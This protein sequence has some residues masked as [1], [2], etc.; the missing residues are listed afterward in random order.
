MNNQIF[1]EENNQ[2]KIDFS[3]ALWASDD[4]HNVYNRLGIC[5][6]D[7]VAETEEF[8]I[9][10]EYKNANI[11]N[12]INPE[13]FETKIRTDGHYKNIAQKFYDSLLYLLLNDKP[14]K[15]LR[16]VYILERNIDDSVLRRSVRNKIKSK[17]P[18][19]IQENYQTKVI[20][21]FDVLSI[22]EWNEAYS[23]YPIVQVME[24]QQ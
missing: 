22:K 15:E 14:V 16:Y 7:W 24:A 9:L 5:D 20:N 10:V 23:D 8:T 1:I 18:F 6:V 3:K 11:P 19:N 12:A 4:I 21:R 2:Y 17:L 13:A